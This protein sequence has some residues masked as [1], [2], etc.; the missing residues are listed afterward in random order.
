MKISIKEMPESEFEK[1]KI[2]ILF[3]DKSIDRTFGVVSDGK[4]EY[5]LGWQS[6]NIKPVIK[7][8]NL[9]LCSIGIDLI[10]VIF[11]LTTG[12]VLQKISLDYYFYDTKIYKGAIYVIT[13]LEIIKVGIQD[14]AIVKIY[15]LP[16]YF[17][18]IEFNEEILVVKCIGDKVV[19]IN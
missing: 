10:F 11:E 9:L 16:D 6:E 12:R 1:L 3:E 13:Q 14:L 17:E 15:S 8:I 7:C 2:P 18:S 4:I 19:N 5:K